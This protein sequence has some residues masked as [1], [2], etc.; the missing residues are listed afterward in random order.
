MPSKHA[1][2]SQ[3]TLRRK[4]SDLVATK[5][6]TRV[7]V[8]VGVIAGALSSLAIIV[9][10]IVWFNGENAWAAEVRRADAQILLNLQQTQNGSRYWQVIGD[11]EFLEYRQEKN[12]S[13]TS[14]E[15]RRLGSLQRELARLEIEKDQLDKLEIELQQKK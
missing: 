7:K 11:L 6:S 12:G 5:W 10:A 8:W 3:T 1:E 13:L 2:E 9:T 15:K 4:A 14:T